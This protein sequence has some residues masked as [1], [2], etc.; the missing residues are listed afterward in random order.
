MNTVNHMGT[1]QSNILV[2]FETVQLFALWYVSVLER[3]IVVA[4]YLLSGE[5][6]E[7]SG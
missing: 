2:E 1:I 6:Q 7:Q 5:G 4:C 3:L